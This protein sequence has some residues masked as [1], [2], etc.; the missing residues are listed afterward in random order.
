M[1][2]ASATSGPKVDSADAL[3][4]KSDDVDWKYGYLSDKNDLNTTMCERCDKEIKGGIYMLKQHVV[5]I[6]TAVKKCNDATKE[7]KKDCANAIKATQEK[8]KAKLAHD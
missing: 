7:E 3:K 8:K 5:G 1:A 4:R 2:S 6:G